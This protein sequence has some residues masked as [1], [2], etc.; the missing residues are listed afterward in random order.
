MC[1]PLLSLFLLSFD[2]FCSRLDL[3]WVSLNW[4]GAALCC[5]ESLWRKCSSFVSSARLERGKESK[6]R[7]SFVL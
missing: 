7:A 1:F 5:A 4:D 6:A 3:P 2:L